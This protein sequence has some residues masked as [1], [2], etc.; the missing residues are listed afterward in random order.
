MTTVN[1]FSNSCFPSTHPP[2]QCLAVGWISHNCV[3]RIPRIAARQ[4]FGRLENLFLD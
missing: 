4:M 3:Y 2:N 1:A